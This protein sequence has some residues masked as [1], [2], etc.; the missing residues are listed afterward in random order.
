MSNETPQ[1]ASAPSNKLT[2]MAVEVKIPMPE[3]YI[4]LSV[5]GDFFKP[6]LLTAQPSGRSA[7]G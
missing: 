1:K 5:P 2:E 3:V 7:K 6:E 4:S